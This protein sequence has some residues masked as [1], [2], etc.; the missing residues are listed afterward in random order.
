MQQ[1]TLDAIDTGESATSEAICGA[2]TASG[3]RCQHKATE[4][5]DP[6]RCWIDSHNDAD[7]P[8]E[9]QP[10]RKEKLVGEEREDVLEAARIGMSLSGMAE[11]AEI[12]ESTLHRWLWRSPDFGWELRLARPPQMRRSGYGWPDSSGRVVKCE[13]CEDEVY[14]TP[15][16]LDRNDH[17][18]C[19]QECHKSWMSQKSSGRVVKCEQC[20]GEVY[21]KPSDLDRNDH[22]FCSQECHKSWMSQNIVGEAHP[23]YE[24]GRS[25]L[26]RGPDWNG[27]RKKAIQRDGGECVACGMSRRQHRDEY[28]YD[29][30]VHHI[31]A[32][33]TFDDLAEANKLSNLVTLCHSCH[34]LYEGSM[35]RPAVQD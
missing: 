3:S 9:Q 7:V 10:G 35:L 1:L 19:S 18:F 2:E 16:A 29:L 13:Q 21:K 8:D 25:R 12:D 20:E 4:K 6:D 5:G 30:H 14:K 32:R 11:Y 23:D 34:G 28:G 33:R 15:S 24:G 22:H 27:Q 31:E 17:H 26:S